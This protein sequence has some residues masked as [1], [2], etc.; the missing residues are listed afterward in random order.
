MHRNA[1]ER[2]KV[3]TPAASPT[4]ALRKNFLISGLQG[5][6]KPLYVRIIT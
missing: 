6:I 4:A 1:T 3:I 2:K 5:P